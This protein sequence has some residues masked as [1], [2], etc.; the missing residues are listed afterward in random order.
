M[1]NLD[2]SIEKSILASVMFSHHQKAD[3]EFFNNIELYEEYFSDKF[4]RLVVKQINYNKALGLS[5]QEEY[6]T[7]AMANSGTLTNQMLE[8]LNANPFSRYLFETY[9]KQLSKPRLASHWD[10]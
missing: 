9:Y 5:Y 2:Y 4:H 8:I 10:I 7:E 6:I 3:E 1:S